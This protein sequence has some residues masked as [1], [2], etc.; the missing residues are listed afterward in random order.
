MASYRVEN[1][2]GTQPGSPPTAAPIVGQADDQPIDLTLVL[3]AFALLTLAWFLAWFLFKAVDPPYFTPS[4]DYSAIAA[5]VLFAT[6]LER[7][8]EPISK[9]LLPD[10]K[11]KKQVDETTTTAANLASD[12]KRGPDEV[13]GAAV[14][15]ATAIAAATKKTN[16]RAIA[17]WALATILALIGPA[18]LGVF[19]LR[20]VSPTSA[21]NRFLDMLITAL[22]V[23]AG[24]KPLHDTIESIQAKKESAQGAPAAGS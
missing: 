9:Y 5:V 17:M 22:I 10:V 6:A 19:F 24:T 2:A 11:E 21:P 20:A 16:E 4:S 1:L 3:V 13:E 12:P 18:C 7:F 14:E 15:A 8:L 23:G